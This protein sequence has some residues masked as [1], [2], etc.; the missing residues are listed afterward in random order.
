MRSAAENDACRVALTS[1]V[2]P[3][4]AAA[5][6]AGSPVPRSLASSFGC[7]FSS[8]W[9]DASA[10]CSGA[11]FWVRVR[12]RETTEPTEPT[13]LTDQPHARCAPW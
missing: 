13:H 6:K 9:Y 8:R 12:V 3:P 10:A 7:V 2:G 11:G 4:P 5:D 1:G